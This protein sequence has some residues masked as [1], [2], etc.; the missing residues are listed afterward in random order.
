MD[1]KQFGNAF[2]HRLFGVFNLRAQGVGAAWLGGGKGGRARADRLSK[3]RKSEIARKAAK[4]RGD[5]KT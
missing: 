2:A 4:A 3:E 5:A 1:T